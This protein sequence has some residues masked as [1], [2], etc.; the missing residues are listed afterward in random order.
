MESAEYD[1]CN[2]RPDGFSGR[3]TV[4][5]LSK[6][7]CSVAPVRPLVRPGCGA[8]VWVYV[9]LGSS[10]QRRPQTR[11]DADAMTTY[12]KFV[13]AS[14]RP[15]VANLAICILRRRDERTAPRPL[16]AYGCAPRVHDAAHRVGRLAGWSCSM[17]VL[18][19]SGEENGEAWS[20]QGRGP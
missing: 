5:M 3:S 8:S 17:T 7:P 13:G 12:S 2:C 6:Q 18:T 19:Q 9:C 11:L 20:T 15:L 1:N 10:G 14:R 4:G 16:L